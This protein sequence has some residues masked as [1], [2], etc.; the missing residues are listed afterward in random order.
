MSLAEDRYFST[1]GIVNDNS[2]CPDEILESSVSYSYRVGL[3]TKQQTCT[4]TMTSGLNHAYR[5]H[6][7]MYK[8]YSKQ[9]V[10]SINTPTS[11]SL[12][13]EV[14]HDIYTPQETFNFFLPSDVIHHDDEDERA[15]VTSC[16][17]NLTV[18]V[19]QHAFLQ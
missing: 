10:N 19:Y 15:P 12:L 13:T 3:A 18:F 6:I 2:T 17:F 8:D 4:V 1:C 14:S 16:I 7:C 5:I 11:C 9:A